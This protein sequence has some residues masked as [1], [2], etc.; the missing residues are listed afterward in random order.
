MPI[1]SRKPPVSMNDFTKR[2]RRFRLDTLA[3]AA[4]AHRYYVPEFEHKNLYKGVP[5]E[6]SQEALQLL[7]HLAKDAIKSPVVRTEEMPSFRTIEILIFAC[8]TLEGDLRE[9]SFDYFALH[10][11][12]W[13]FLRSLQA[14][15]ALEDKAFQ[16]VLMHGDD[17]VA[18][19]A[20]DVQA[21]PLRI[22]HTVM[23]LAKSSSNSTLSSHADRRKVVPI[24]T[25]VMAKFVEE[26]GSAG[27]DA[28][29]EMFG[30]DRI[31]Y[32]VDEETEALAMA[33]AEV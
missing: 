9:M 23:H 19:E 3:S 4:V 1:Q 17:W 13:D 25:E 2:E 28:V 16:M 18:S 30:V 8:S 10:L 20:D 15:F 14:H 7:F 11:R 12:C 22:L 5:G 21:N 24:T 6:E 27:I 26:Q 31:V 33:D 32:E 29:T